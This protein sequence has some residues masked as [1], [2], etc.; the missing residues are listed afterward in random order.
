MDGYGDNDIGVGG[1]LPDSKGT[2]FQVN[3]NGICYDLKHSPYTFMRLGLEYRFSSPLHR[4]RFC[5]RLAEREDWACDSLSRRFKCNFDARILAAM[6]LYSKIET[7]GFSVYDSVGEVEYES[8]QEVRLS[9]L[10][11]T[12]NGHPNS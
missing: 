8:W 5:E 12:R 7:R 10:P 4:K 9:G 6:Q 3:A 11:S 2:T 1:F